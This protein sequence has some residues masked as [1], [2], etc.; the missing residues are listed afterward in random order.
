MWSDKQ[1]RGIALMEVVIAL[2]VVSVLLPV[3]MLGVRTS[4]R[5]ASTANLTTESVLINQRVIALIE[6]I[7]RDTQNKIITAW[8]EDQ[9]TE[10]FAFNDRDLTF[11][12]I[13]KAKFEQGYD[14]KNESH[15]VSIFF[16]KDLQNER[17]VK[18]R[19]A[20]T[21][22]VIAPADSREKTEFIRLFAK[23][24]KSDRSRSL[25]KDNL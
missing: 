8:P 5:S 3:L 12:R 1:R 2:G 25:E 17:L 19:I 6:D 13:D 23:Q 16:E 20:I 4:K 21:A 9:T 24:K 14:D 18:C 22:P 11:Q 7:N 15:L 10:H